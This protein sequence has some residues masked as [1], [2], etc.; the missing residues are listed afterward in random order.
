MPV[1]RILRSDTGA[2]KQPYASHKYAVFA[3]G[4]VGTFMA[5]LDG[6]ILTVALPTI[7]TQFGVG[8]DAAAWVVLSYSLTLISLMMLFGAWT[9]RKGYLFAYLFGYVVFT[10]GSLCCALSTS[11]EFLVASRVLQ[12]VGT[13]MFSALG[14]GLVTT[15]FPAQERGKGI[16]LMIMMV[17][18]GFMIGF[19]LGGFLLKVWSWPWLFLINLPIGLLGILMTFRFLRQLPVPSPN[20]PFPLAG[21]IALSVS[22]VS[23]TYGFTLLHDHAFLSANVLT[24]F[25]LSIVAGLAFL[26]C[27]SNPSRAL[28]G[29][30]I[31]A[32][33]SFRNAILAQTFQ[34]LATSGT[35]VILPFYFQEIRQYTPDEVG[36]HFLLFPL[37]M[38]VGAPISG[39]LTDRI[40]VRPLSVLGMIIVAV[41]LGLMAQFSPESSEMLIVSAICLTGLGVG[42]FSTPN[43]TAMMN[44]VREQERPI[45]SGI[46][47]TN[48]NIG[49]SI[50]VAIASTIFTYVRDR[51]A[52]PGSPTAFAS[53]FKAVALVSLGCAVAGLLVCLFRPTGMAAQSG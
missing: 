11:L 30:G 51:A 5:T 6:S 25:G 31:F 53:G 46:L 48:R 13:A 33:P 29:L 10:L 7:A 50:G 39:R 35:M 28:I 4:A 18:A 42:I 44:S 47:A 52:M 27:E 38:F 2:G 9:E 17:S 23:L 22:L 12:A 3:V 21:G 32:N 1:N 34:F 15:V 43:S 8:V 40:G 26:W 14:P 16:G 45:A 49:M 20:R 24:T 41:G 36:L 19:P 37:L